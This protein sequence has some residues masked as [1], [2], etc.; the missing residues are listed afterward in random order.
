VINR[1]IKIEEI[2]LKNAKHFGVST[3]EMIAIIKKFNPVAKLYYIEYPVTQVNYVKNNNTKETFD[4][5]F[6]ARITKDKGIEDL[7]KAISIVK[8]EKPDVSL[9]VIGHTNKRYLDY[10]LKMIKKLDI[11]QNVVF[12]GFFETQ[13]EI[14]KYAL[15]AKICV[16]PTYHDIIPGTIIESMLM[17]LPVI[18]YAVGGIPELNEQGE[19]IIL[20]ETRNIILLASSILNLLKDKNRRN[21]IAKYAYSVANLRY[22]NKIILKDNLTAYKTILLEIY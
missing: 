10:L 3:K 17:K 22:N 12:M 14:Y 18:A 7:L 5:I 6:F 16:L 15:N 21:T 8:K 9:R 4:I 20:V 1:R 19:A 2:I 13:E 11:E